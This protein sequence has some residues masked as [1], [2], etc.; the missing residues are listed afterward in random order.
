MEHE[1]VVEWFKFADI[2]LASAEYLRGM[3][4]QPLEIICYHCQQSAEKYLKGFL[5][6]SG[7]MEPPKTH[8]LDDLCELCYGFDELFSEIRKACS[9]LTAYGVQPR[10]PNEMLIDESDMKKAIEYAHQIR[11]FKALSIVRNEIMQKNKQLESNI[12]I[13]NDNKNEGTPP[14]I[15]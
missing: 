11:D 12:V 10:Y 15:T 8:N 6:Y 1:Y 14:N 5:I 2:D 9:I 3:H 13:P 7:V 4:P